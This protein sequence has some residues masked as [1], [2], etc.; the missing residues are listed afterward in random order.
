[1]LRVC[2]ECHAPEIVSG[3]RH[4]ESGWREVV[5]S[6]EAMGAQGTTSDLDAIIHYL[7]RNFS[8]EVGPKQ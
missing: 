7:T 2:S 6:M 8:P 3:Q 4:P 1:L 5:E